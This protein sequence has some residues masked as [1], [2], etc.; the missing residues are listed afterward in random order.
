MRKID[1]LLKYIKLFVNLYK[2]R[3]T[4]QKL[5][6]SKNIAFIKFAPPGHY[7]S[8]IP[9]I[10]NIISNA[11]TIFN[12]SEKDVP[13]I[14]LHENKQIQLLKSFSQ[15]Y[16]DL[17]FPDK[18]TKQFRYFFDNPF[19]S[20]G[21]GITL[22]SF[23][24][25]FKPKRVIEI[26]SGYTSALMLDTN[27]LFLNNEVEFTFNEP[28]P[29]RLKRLVN[30]NDKQKVLIEEKPVQ[31][32]ELSVF[33]SLEENDILFIDSSHV[34]KINSDVLHIFF[35]ILPCL[36]KGVIIHFHDILWPFEYPKI[37]L[38]E[39]FAWNEAYFLRAFLHNNAAFEILYFNSYLALHH[40][41]I[42]EEMMPKVLKVPSSKITPGNTS[43]WLKKCTD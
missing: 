27:D 17:P 15:F 10:R 31:E 22:Y 41:N 7:H 29:E 16:K 25:Y 33:S 38:E 20:Y 11:D 5:L 19:F 40:T 13:S 12:N 8:P 23:L 39:G 2:E 26:G 3:D 30:E 36:K 14:N 32:V 35:H 4:I 6:E 9:D 42:I 18:K 1:Q 21:D 24:R 28:F 37:W 34:A 43:L